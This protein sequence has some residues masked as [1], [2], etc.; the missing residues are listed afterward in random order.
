MVS[1][2]RQLSLPA[3][4]LCPLAPA[5]ASCS[6]AARR[7][8][9]YGR[10]AVT[11]VAPTPAAAEPAPLNVRG[12]HRS[13]GIRFAWPAPFPVVQ[14][15]KAQMRMGI[16]VSFDTVNEAGASTAAILT[17]VA[18]ADGYEPSPTGWTS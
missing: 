15:P 18:M 14:E 12:N 8:D 10:S 16:E 1:M 6:P 7:Q 3:P 13:G 17:L 11:S 2:G 5:S 9:R 4:A